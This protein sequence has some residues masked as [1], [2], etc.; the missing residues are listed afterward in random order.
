VISSIEEKE[1]QG[2]VLLGRDEAASTECQVKMH[3]ALSNV[4]RIFE[5][6]ATRFPFLNSDEVL[7]PVANLVRAIKGIENS[8]A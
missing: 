8:T 7:D 1:E 3:E 2:E 5:S 6:M 4:M